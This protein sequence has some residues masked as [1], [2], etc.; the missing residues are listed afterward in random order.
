MLRKHAWARA[1][2]LAFGLAAFTSGALAEDRG[3]HGD[4]RGTAGMPASPTQ[5]GHSPAGV[6]GGEGG[7]GGSGSSTEH[8]T[9]ERPSTM[10]SAGGANVA[11][12]TGAAPGRSTQTGAGGGKGG[13]GGSGGATE[14]PT[15]HNR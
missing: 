14:S 7:E 10:G 15:S 13:E 12:T 2:V 5:G 8:R 6:G 9:G 4:P 3:K 11:P 1:G